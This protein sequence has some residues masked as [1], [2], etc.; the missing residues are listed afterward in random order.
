MKGLAGM[1]E[2]ST[3][4][5]MRATARMSGVSSERSMFTGLRKSPR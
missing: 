5:E 4:S 3:L 1:L 2:L